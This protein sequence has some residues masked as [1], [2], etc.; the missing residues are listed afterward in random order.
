VLDDGRIRDEGDDRIEVGRDVSLSGI[1]IDR[2]K[3]ADE[4]SVV[5]DAAAAAADV[6]DDDAAGSVTVF[7]TE[8]TEARIDDK[9]LEKLLMTGSS[10]VVVEDAAAAAVDEE[11]PKT[12][13]RPIVN[14]IDEELAALSSVVELADPSSLVD[15]GDDDD[16]DDTAMLE[17]L[18]V[19]RMTMDGRKPDDAIDAT[20]PTIEVVSVSVVLEETEAEAA[21]GAD[22]GSLADDVSGEESA[23]D[24]LDV[25]G[26]VELEEVPGTS[27]A[28]TGTTIAVEN[29]TSVDVGPSEPA[30]VDAAAPES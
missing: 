27:D 25:E 7:K 28:G 2:L 12:V 19:G 6:V 5:D 14:P 3:A 8:V 11:P 26:S 18:V 30:P 1:L 4:E 15:D 23:E 20:L 16:D 17:E 22:A 29:M 9:A 10:D 13:D 21:V 24:E